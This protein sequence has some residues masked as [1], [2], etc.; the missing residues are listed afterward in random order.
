MSAI[1]QHRFD[2]AEWPRL[3]GTYQVSST[4]SAPTPIR[5]I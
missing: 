5:I 4:F 3:I 1:V 2:P